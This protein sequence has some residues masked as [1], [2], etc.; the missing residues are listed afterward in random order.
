MRS[1]VSLFPQC[2]NDDFLPDCSD[3]AASYDGKS[4]FVLT[5]T[6]DLIECE[7]LMEERILEEPGPFPGMTEKTITKIAVA[8]GSL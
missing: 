4:T 2:Y 1:N 7:A 8:S 3:I 6:G 5:N